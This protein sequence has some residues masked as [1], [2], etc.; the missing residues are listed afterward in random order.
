MKK[1]INHP[2]DQE[3]F[4]LIAALLILLVLTVMGIAVNRST[5]TEWRIAMNDREQKETFYAAD[6][7]TELAA[8]VLVQNIACQGFVENVNGMVLPGV[9]NEHNVYLKEHAVGF[10]RFYAPD[11]TAVPSYGLDGWIRDGTLQPQAIPQDGVPDGDYDCDTDGN[12]VGDNVAM[13]Y[14]CNGTGE[15]LVPAWDIAYPAAVNSSDPATFDWDTMIGSEPFVNNE[16][17]VLIK[18]G[19]ET[20]AK[21][22][23]ALQMA[24][25]YLG[26]GQGAAGGGTELIYDIKA[27]Q[28]GRNGS[29]SLVCVK[30]VHV[31]G[32]AG[33]CNY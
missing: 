3:G 5:I 14:P 33:N 11:G 6:A 7:A 31:L 27:R 17:F 22:G 9:D 13:D 23:S 2:K 10:W 25:G 21:T 19:G 8:E 16:P 15:S 12:G 28:R 24:A 4:V 20:K 32:S 26:L 30:Y 18:I 29:E 1:T